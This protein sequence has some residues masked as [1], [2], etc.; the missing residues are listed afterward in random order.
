[1]QKITRGGVAYNLELSPYRYNV[2][3]GDISITYVFS[4]EFYRNNFLKKLKCNRVQISES[5]SKR[6]GVCVQFDTLA[7]LKLYTHIE[8]RGFLIYQNGERFECLS[9]LRLDGESLTMTH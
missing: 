4:S 3:Y 9:S 1:M 2:N 8:K 5:L 7:D 6:F